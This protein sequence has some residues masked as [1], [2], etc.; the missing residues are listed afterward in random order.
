MTKLA[1]LGNP[2]AM[3]VEELQELRRLPYL[4]GGTITNANMVLRNKILKRK[5]KCAYESCNKEASEEINTTILENKKIKPYILK[6]CKDCYSEY[7]EMME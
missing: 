6:V 1:F 4:A 5:N 3:S 7:K 2:E